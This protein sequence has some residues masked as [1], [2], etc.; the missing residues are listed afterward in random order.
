M[1]WHRT[2]TRTRRSGR[3]RRRRRRT[4]RTIAIAIAKIGSQEFARGELRKGHYKN[5]IVN[6]V[7]SRCGVFLLVATVSI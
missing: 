2:R 5:E 1:G 7:F 4:T 6:A 3:R